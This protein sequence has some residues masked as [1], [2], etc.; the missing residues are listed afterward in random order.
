MASKMIFDLNIPSE[1]ARF[2]LPENHKINE[3]GPSKLK[4]WSFKDSVPTLFIYTL[5]H[6]T[7]IQLA[8]YQTHYLYQI[9]YAASSVYIYKL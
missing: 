2:G 1:R 6:K 3:F 9:I 8:T 7:T 5:L 4:L